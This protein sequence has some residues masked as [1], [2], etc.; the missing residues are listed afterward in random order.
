MPMIHTPCDRTLGKWQ[1][2]VS[3]RGVAYDFIHA[4][5][6]LAS[7]RVRGQ[8]CAWALEL[9]AG[10]RRVLGPSKVQWGSF[11]HVFS[12]QQR[13][14]GRGFGVSRSLHFDIIDNHT[15]LFSFSR[16]TQHD[17]SVDFN[18][19]TKSFR[20]RGIYQPTKAIASGKYK[21][22]Q[23]EGR[24]NKLPQSNDFTGSLQAWL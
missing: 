17:A 1:N 13:V 3:I 18:D 8:D 19:E 5:R 12:R 10:E 7:Y 4:P 23:R 6:E 21:D 9:S 20:F 11:E 15:R 14:G 16:S 24:H 2:V 22:A